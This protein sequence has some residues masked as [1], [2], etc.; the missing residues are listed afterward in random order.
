[1]FWA[2]FLFCCTACVDPVEPEFR[3]REG[4]LIVDGRLS[5]LP[6]AS[7]LSLTEATREGE[8][9]R[10]SPLE[11]QLVQTLDGQGNTVEWVF[12]EAQQRYLPPPGFV[13]TIGETYALRFV[14]PNG[15]VFESDPEPLLPPV[16]LT[17]FRL[18]FRQESYFSSNLNRFVPAFE[19]FTTFNEPADTEDHYRFSYL[20]WEMLDRC[21]TC[22]FQ[23]V[24][25]IT[26]R[27]EDSFGTSGIPQYDYPCQGNCWEVTRYGDGSLLTDEL[28]NGNTLVDFT[29]GA[30]DY[31]WFGPLLVVAQLERI[32]PNAHEYYEVLLQQVLASGGL[33][34]TL[35]AS[36][37][38]NVFATEPDANTTVVGYFA[39]SGM[40]EERI[41]FNRDTVSGTPLP[42]DGTRNLDIPPPPDTIYRHP[43]EGPDRSTQRPLGWPE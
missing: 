20:S 35:P 24:N 31:D 40:A 25:R 18:D 17:D 43:C 10:L 5:N 12:R 2:L 13:P 1:M 28:V 7:Y 34:A 32:S 23:R 21:L 30:I 29:V 4:L 41:Y 27:C 11:T 6:G 16:E 14:S 37:E 38:G 26:M 19:L 42:F 8:V 9:Y 39:V 22:N 33:S 36:L 15:R 3:F